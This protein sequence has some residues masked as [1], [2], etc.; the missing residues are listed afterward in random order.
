MV[1][2]VGQHI[3]LERD[4]RSLLLIIGVWDDRVH[5]IYLLSLPLATETVELAF[6]AMEDY[7]RYYQARCHNQWLELCHSPQNTKSARIRKLI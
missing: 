6:T 5:R 2:E 4:M 3:S 1:I 7:K